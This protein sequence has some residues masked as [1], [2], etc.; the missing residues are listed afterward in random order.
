MGMLFNGDFDWSQQTWIFYTFP[1]AGAILAVVLFEF[2]F[3]KAQETVE[4]E[5]P[6][7]SSEAL[8]M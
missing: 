1:L 8:L 4:E 7:Q 3:K 5:Q 2:V 6:D